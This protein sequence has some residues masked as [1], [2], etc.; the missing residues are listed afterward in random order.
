VAGTALR[1]VLSAPE[2]ST[3]IPG[4]RT[5]RNVERN[6]ALADGQG[7]PEEQRAKLARHRWER[8]FYPSG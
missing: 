3:V 5:V 7:L 4:M 8:N 1:Y 2:V 6:A